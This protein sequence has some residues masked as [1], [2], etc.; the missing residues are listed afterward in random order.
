MTIFYSQFYI[1]F[2]TN[3]FLLMGRWMPALDH[4]GRSNISIWLKPDVKTAKC[5]LKNTLKSCHFLD[6]SDANKT[7]FFP[8]FL[9]RAFTSGSIKVHIFWEGH[10]ILQNFHFTFVLYS[11]SQKWGEEFA[12]FC[13]LLR[14]YV[15]TLQTSLILLLFYCLMCVTPFHLRAS[16]E[17]DAAKMAHF[18]TRQSI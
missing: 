14:I 6:E 4:D 15:W 9:A 5:K 17:I 8:D 18:L 12:K 7:S 10:T 16:N 1:R 2:Q 13:G 3:N 11:V